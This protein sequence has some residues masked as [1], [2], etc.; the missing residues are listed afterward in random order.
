MQRHAFIDCLAQFVGAN[1]MPLAGG[2]HV[3][4]VEVA[5]APQQYRQA[6]HALAS[7]EADLDG[8]TVTV[9]D[10]IG[11]P[12]IRKIDGLDWLAAPLKHLAQREIDRF[13]MRLE[14]PEI[15]TRKARKDEI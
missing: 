11:K 12:A 14:Q 3:N 10:D 15:S 4:L 2:L 13:Q 7:N 1:A 8:S 9:G 6:C 5:V